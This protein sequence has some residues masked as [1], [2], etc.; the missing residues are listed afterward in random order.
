MSDPHFFIG[1]AGLR[2]AAD[3]G[4]EASALSVILMHGGGQTRHSWRRAFDDLVAGGYHVISFD[5]RGH[6]DSGWAADG[7]YTL[8]AFADDLRSVMATLPR[9][10]ALVGASL[11][12]AAA[13]TVAGDGYSRVSALVMVDIVPRLEPAGADHIIRFMSS[14]TGGFADLEEAADAVAAYNPA[15]PRPKNSSGLMRNLRRHED[16][17]L[18]WHWDP[19]FIGGDMAPE[20]P[21]FTEPLL[22]AADRVQAP[23]LVIRGAL[24]DVVSDAGVEDFREHLPGLEVFNVGG[25][26]HMVAGDKNDAFNTAILDF[27]RRNPGG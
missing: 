3:V 20:P 19:A 12:G 2:L 27:L 5:L 6:G 9:P 8:D 23:T 1:R 21:R 22:E 25:A 11:G 14:N 24:S 16:G 26:G 7:D 4:G 15:R 13:L 17:R 18:Y 10:P